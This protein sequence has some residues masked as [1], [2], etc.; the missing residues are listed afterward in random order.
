M[1]IFGMTDMGIVRKAN[2]DRFSAKRISDTL[3]FA[4]VCDGM[5]G[6]SGGHI[7]SEKTC[8]I[9]EA[10]LSEKAE[11]AATSQEMQDLLISVVSE[12]NMEVYKASNIEPGC[13]GMGTTAVVLII[14]DNRAYLAH[15]GD[16]RIY[17]IEN[18]A[19]SQLT[20]DHS[21]VQELVDC[22]KI[23]QDE[24]AYHP[25]KNMITRAIGVNLQVDIDYLELSVNPNA[26]FLL[27]TDGLT[28]MVSIEEIAEIINRENIEEACEKLILLANEKGGTDN[29][30]AVIIEQEAANG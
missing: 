2:Q 26:K 6:Q 30:T 15:V 28:N 14:K 17:L 8:S 29:I 12:A 18:E 19:L 13:K 3:C 25:N 27:C 10:R 16:S 22:G 9:I 1:R 23:S 5:G 24:A 4:V 11:Q 21:L 20:H 7:A